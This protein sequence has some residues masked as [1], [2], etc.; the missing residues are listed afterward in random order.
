MCSLCTRV[1]STSTSVS[2]GL[3]TRLEIRTQP[4]SYLLGVLRQTVGPSTWEVL[5]RYCLECS[6][7][8]GARHRLPLRYSLPITTAK[9]HLTSE[10]Q[11]LKKQTRIEETRITKQF[12]QKE[13]KKKVPHCM[14][15]SK[16]APSRYIAASILRKCLQTK[17]GASSP[18]DRASTPADSAISHKA[19]AIVC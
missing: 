1:P 12:A 13:M 19:Q 7:M 11:G 3:Y 9:I 5:V 17:R 8:Q 2:R 4:L 18:G 10:Q 15:S 6:S 16:G 14:H